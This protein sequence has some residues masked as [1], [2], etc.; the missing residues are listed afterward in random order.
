MS[1]EDED[2]KNIRKSIDIVKNIR[3]MGYDAELYILNLIEK[4]RN[5][6][7]SIEFIQCIIDVIYTTID[8]GSANE[9]E[10]ELFIET[11]N[12]Q[13]HLIKLSEEYKTKYLKIVDFLKNMETIEKEGWKY[14][15]SAGMWVN[16]PKVVDRMNVEDLSKVYHEICR[17][18]VNNKIGMITKPTQPYIEWEALTEGQRNGRRFIAQKLLEKYRMLDKKDKEEIYYN[19][20]LEHPRGVHG[21]AINEATNEIG[22]IDHDLSGEKLTSNL[23]YDLSGNR[24][25]G[26]DLC[27]IGIN[28][29]IEPHL[30]CTDCWSTFGF[31]EK[32]KAIEDSIEDDG[33]NYYNCAKCGHAVSNHVT[34]SECNC[35]KYTPTLYKKS[36]ESIIFNNELKELKRKNEE[37]IKEIA[38]LKK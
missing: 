27:G 9:K 12:N 31:S 18:M 7:V 13:G 24:I 38:K 36:E 11:M 2:T 33:K 37:L 25:Y 20:Q 10:I 28:S 15:N 23:V 16:I 21:E 14:I 6:N 5:P 22:V 32:A 35:K 8:S 1:E 34:C 19:W 17:E 29:N 30:L 4:I 3:N 26:C